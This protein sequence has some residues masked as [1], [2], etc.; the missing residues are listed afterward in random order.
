MNTKDQLTIRFGGDGNIKVETLTN[1]LSE[2]KELFHLINIELG[3]NADDLIIEVSPPEHGSFKIK[4]KPKYKSLILDKFGDLTVAT[5]TGLILLF[6]SNISNKEDLNEIKRLLESKEISNKEY[7]DSIHKS[8]KNPTIVN[9]IQQTFVTIN[10]DDNVTS[11]N[12]DKDNKEFVS[13][14][15]ESF[16]QLI[17]NIQQE[18]TPA[19]TVEIHEDEAI[20]I[21]KTIHFEGGAK[22]AFIYRG[23]PIKASINDPVFLKRLNK[24][25]FMK[26]DSLK[27]RLSRKREFDEDLQTFII[28]QSSYRIEKVIEHKS[29][30]DNNQLDF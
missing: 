8:Y 19:K 11:L 20:L 26:G 16:S 30:E 23:Y 15:K 3:Y 28:D 6:A 1:F 24:E 27:V 13:I 17:L 29:R 5:L 12:L 22:W 4:L 9:K 18:E 10:E 7:I 25:S 2:Y 21:I 14:Q